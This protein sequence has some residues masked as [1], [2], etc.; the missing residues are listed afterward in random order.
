MELKVKKEVEETVN[1]DLP[2]FFKAKNEQRYIGILNEDQ[3]ISFSQSK[4]LA[5]YSNGDLWL[6]KSN[7]KEAIN[8]WEPITEEQFLLIHQDFLNMQSLSPQLVNE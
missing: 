1:I 4:G 3:V 2:V 5:N 7:I 6:F 8:E